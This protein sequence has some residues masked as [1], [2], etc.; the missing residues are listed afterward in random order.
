MLVLLFLLDAT[1]DNWWGLVTSEERLN[2]VQMSFLPL[3]PF[4]N[5][6]FRSS[7]LKILCATL[8]QLLIHVLNFAHCR[9]LFAPNILKI[10]RLR[11]AILIQSVGA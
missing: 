2:F 4:I 10:Y 8:K 11:E 9:T 3:Y 6:I 7:T 1:K 5:R